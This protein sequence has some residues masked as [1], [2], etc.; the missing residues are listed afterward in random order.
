MGVVGRPRA[1]SFRARWTGQFRLKPSQAWRSCEAWQ[2][3]SSLALARIFHMRLAMGGVLP[4]VVRDTYVN[5]RARMLAKLFDLIPV[6]D[7]AGPELDTSELVTYLN[8]AI[9]LAP[10]ML[11]MPMADWSP[12]DDASFDVALT[13]EG[14]TVTGRVF[15]DDRGAPR[16]FSTEDR[17][18]NDPFTKGHPFVRGRWTTPV[19]GWTVGDGR[20]L[21]TRGRAV[22]HFASGTFTYADFSLDAACLAHNVPPGE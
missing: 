20:A 1:W 21:P 6:V 9:L 14:R 5:G 7:A 8:D 13:N 22:W 17:F 11:L 18:G 2:Y 19:E 16:D 4:T 15:I 10:S 12:V 3:N